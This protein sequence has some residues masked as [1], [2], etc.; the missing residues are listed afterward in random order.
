M[1]W[2]KV[3]NKYRKPFGWWYHKVLCELWWYGG[4]RG[5]HYYHHLNKLCDYGFNLYGD[6]I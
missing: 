2:S 6:K 5:K 1:S 4:D 3:N